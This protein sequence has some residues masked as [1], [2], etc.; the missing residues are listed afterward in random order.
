MSTRP[1]PDR[2][3]AKL[4][5]LSRSIDAGVVIHLDAV[6]E[7]TITGRATG[8]ILAGWIRDELSITR[9]RLRI[10]CRSAV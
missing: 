6:D 9:P 8:R 7:A 3:E 1:S 2:L 4:K 5:E 10:S